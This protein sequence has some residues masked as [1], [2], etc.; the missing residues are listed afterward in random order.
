[1][2]QWRFYLLHDSLLIVVAQRAAE[3]VVV[4]G[5]TVLLHAPQPCNL[6]GVRQG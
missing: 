1:M 3:F 4:H 2:T 5:W 6:G